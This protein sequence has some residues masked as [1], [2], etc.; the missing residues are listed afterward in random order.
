MMGQKVKVHA[1]HTPSLSPSSQ[2]LPLYSFGAGSDL[3]RPINIPNALTRED[4]GLQGHLPS[5][6]GHTST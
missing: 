1:N 5:S 4:H 3:G 6:R 2:P